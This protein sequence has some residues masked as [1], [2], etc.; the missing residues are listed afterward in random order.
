M[1][2]RAQAAQPPFQCLVTEHAG[3]VAGFLRGMLDPED[4]EECAQETF[5]AAL[6][7]YDSFDGRHPRAWLL[8]I[9]RRKAIDHRRAADRRPR[10]SG[11]VDSLAAPERSDA[12]DPG[13][14]AEVAELPDK[15]RAALLLR[16]GLDLRYREIGEVLDCSEAAARRSAHEGIAKLRTGRVEEVA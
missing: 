12:S 10:P 14:W 7:A 8:A 6:R 11:E 1:A 5:V 16:Y 9:A 2:R 13:I 3:S 15:Q 4:A